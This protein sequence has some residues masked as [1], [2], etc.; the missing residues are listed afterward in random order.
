MAIRLPILHF[1]TEHY[2]SSFENKISKYKILINYQNTLNGNTIIIFAYFR[3]LLL[4]KGF[5]HITLKLEGEKKSKR[6]WYWVTAA[7]KPG[8]IAAT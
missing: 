2:T 8:P 5:K 3:N 1:L 4:K 7:S 6:Q